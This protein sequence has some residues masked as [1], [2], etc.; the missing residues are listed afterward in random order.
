LTLP[1][2]SLV[3]PLSVPALVVTFEKLGKSIFTANA[4]DATA[5]PSTQAAATIELKTFKRFITNT[6]LA[7]LVS[8]YRSGTRPIEYETKQTPRP[9]VFQ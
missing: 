5:T 9:T 3:P 1:N 6:P 2:N 7:Y 4:D 8:D